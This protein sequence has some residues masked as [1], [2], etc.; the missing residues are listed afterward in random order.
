VS[1]SFDRFR[2]TGTDFQEARLG[3]MERSRVCVS[4]VRSALSEISS[5]ER[6]DRAEAQLAM[7]ALARLRQAVTHLERA[8]QLDHTVTSKDLELLTLTEG[9][10]FNE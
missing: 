8:I 2:L 3:H 9:L 4:Y 5:G 1:K 7:R 10:K 6:P